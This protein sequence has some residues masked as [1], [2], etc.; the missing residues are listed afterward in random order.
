MQRRDV[1][2]LGLNVRPCR[3]RGAR[4]VDRWTTDRRILTWAQL[5][6]VEL[7]TN[8]AKMKAGQP[9]E[10]IAPLSEKKP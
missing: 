2:S 4:D 7:E 9:L 5:H 8:W 1:S 6:R 10:S 3:G